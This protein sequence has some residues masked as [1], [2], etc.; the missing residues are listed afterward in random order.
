MIDEKSMA[1]K[2]YL[3]KIHHFGN[4][5]HSTNVASNVPDRLIS[6]A[7]KSSLK[8]TEE[9]IKKHRRVNQNVKFA[10]I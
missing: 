9:L 1:N 5:G 2:K 10:A 4:H 7:Q 6:K 8:S 3:R